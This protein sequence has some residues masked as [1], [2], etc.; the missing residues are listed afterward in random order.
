MSI[1]DWINESVPGGLRSR[2]GKLLD[3][4]YNIEYGG[5]TTCR[6]R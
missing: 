1:V 4:A 3:V 5:E 6:A 2:L